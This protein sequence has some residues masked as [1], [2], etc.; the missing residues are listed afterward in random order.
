MISSRSIKR[1]A[2]PENAKP[3]KNATNAAVDARTRAI[4]RSKGSSAERISEPSQKPSSWAATTPAIRPNATSS[5]VI[6]GPLKP[7]SAAE[8]PDEF[9]PPHGAYPKAKDHELIIALCITAKA[10]RLCPLWVIRVGP[11]QPAAS[12]DVR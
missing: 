2:A 1:D 10:A 6:R 8:K 3:T 12:P 7:E 11:K 9:P 5:S 4:C